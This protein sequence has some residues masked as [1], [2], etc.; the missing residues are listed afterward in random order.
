MSEIEFT[1]RY[2]ALGI[3]YPDPETMCIRGYHTDCSI[4]Q[5][6]SK[7]PLRKRNLDGD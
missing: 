5:S 4:I 7:I 1:D 3:P 6:N 2:P